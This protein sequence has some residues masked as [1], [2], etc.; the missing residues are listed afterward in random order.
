MQVA[1]QRYTFA[2]Y[3]EL[4]AMSP[5]KHEYYGGQVWAMAGGSPAHAGVC[6]NVSTTLA[7]QLRDRPCRV[8]GSDLRVRVR[9]TG[10]ATYPDVSVVCGALEAD[11]DD[12]GKHTVVNPIVV[13]EV[14]S[15][16]TEDYDRG[17]K[18]AHYKTIASLQEMALVAH[19]QRRIELW[20][21]VESGWALEVISDRGSL[22]LAS[23]G[24]RLELDEVYRDPLA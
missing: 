15:P 5:I 17:E 2:E 11:P 21:R 20:R 16:S 3:L 18:L 23:I 14:L 6:V 13:V 10:L 8:F 1:R 4:E 7:N 24:C 19:D 12:R 22:D 9:E